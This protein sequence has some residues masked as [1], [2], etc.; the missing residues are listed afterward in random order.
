MF[1]TVNR[2]HRSGQL[3]HLPFRFYEYDKAA[4]TGFPKVAK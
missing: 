4:G 3:Q 1:L 2:G